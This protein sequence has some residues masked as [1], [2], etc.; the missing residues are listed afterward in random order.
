MFVVADQCAIGIGGKRRFARAGQAEENGHVVF[1]AAVIRRTVHGHHAFLRQQV[2]HH[3]KDGFLDFTGVRGAA[4]Q[5]QFLSKMQQH[6][7]FGVRAVNGR[8]GVKI[9]G[10][11]DGKFRNVLRQLFRIQL[12]DKHGAGEQRGPSPL[13][14][15]ANR[16]A[17]LFVRPR[18]A[19][20]NENILSLQ[21]RAE[22]VLEGVKFRGI[23]RA[24]DLAPGNVVFA[25]RFAHEKAILRQAPGV[26]ARAHNQWAEMTQRSFIAA[27]GLFVER[28]RGQIPID[29]PEIIE[30][31][32]SETLLLRRDFRRISF[33]EL[34]STR[35]G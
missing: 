21:I 20:L 2:I 24:I 18:V 32:I 11:Q 30:T 7:C 15:H 31:E 34:S 35:S 19:V 10:V 3:R 33:C 13:A 25:G 14:D 9:R 28:G 29:A 1:I 27:N 17:I 23:E 16:N 12:A 22:P 8:V 6:E 26:L 4:N 5:N